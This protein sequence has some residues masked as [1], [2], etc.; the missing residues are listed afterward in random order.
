[1]LFAVV[2]VCIVT[3]PLARG[4]L[5]ALADVRFRHPELLVGAFLLQ[6]AVMKLWPHR[7]GVL[8]PVLYLGSYA[9]GSWFVVRNRRVPGL[10]LVGLG[11]AMNG[12]AIAANGGVMPG[13][14]HAF[15]AAGLAPS[16]DHFVNSRAVEHARLLFLGDVFAVPDPLPFHNVFSLGDVCIV[17]GVFVGLH[18]IASSR[19][20]RR[21]L[22]GSRSAVV[23]LL[24]DGRRLLHGATGP[25]QAPLVD[26]QLGPACV[27]RLAQADHGQV[28]QLLGDA[29]EPCAD[30]VELTGHAAPR[31]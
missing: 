3:V 10:W 12:L 24:Q 29:F 7:P 9:L 5:S 21:R 1:M 16:P 2:V 25:G 4:R 18:R 8:H 28:G 26:R 19:L 31:R 15:R 20:L 11:A 27:D 6:V 13:P 22:P 30:V 23:R 17:A 14:P